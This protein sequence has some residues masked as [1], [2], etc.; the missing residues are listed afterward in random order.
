[1]PLF[2]PF[3]LEGGEFNNI[4]NKFILKDQNNGTSIKTEIT[5]NSLKGDDRLVGFTA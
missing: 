3:D 5:K 2:W 1:M 4:L